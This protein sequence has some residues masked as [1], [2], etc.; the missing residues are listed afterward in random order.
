MDRRT[1]AVMPSPKN[2]FVPALRLLL[3]WLTCRWSWADDDVGD[4]G[5]A[6]DAG[7]DAAGEDGDA[8][9][10]SDEWRCWCHAW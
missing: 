10:D 8:D 6:S 9:Q 7:D 3:Q 5:D 4:A 2:F 1:S